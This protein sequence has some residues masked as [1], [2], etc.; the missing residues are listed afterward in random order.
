M[1]SL[2]YVISSTVGFFYQISTDR[3]LK[4]F[5]QDNKKYTLE[6]IISMLKECLFV[7]FLGRPPERDI[8]VDGNAV[9]QEMKNYHN[10]NFPTQKFK[11]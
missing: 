8:G 9:Y 10:T 2:R 4:N 11:S 7:C 1:L 3:P 6:S 5:F